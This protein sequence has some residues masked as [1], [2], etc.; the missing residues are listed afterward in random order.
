MSK[1]PKQQRGK[2]TRAAVFTTATIVSFSFTLLAAGIAVLTGLVPLHS[3]TFGQRVDIGSLLFMMP[4]VALVLGM[5]VE[6]TRIALRPQQL[7]ET[8]EPQQIRWSQASVDK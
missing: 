8:N 2:R 3:L 5:C 1:P 4:V 7:P 6:V